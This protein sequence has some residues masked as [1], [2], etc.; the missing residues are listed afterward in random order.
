MLLRAPPSAP[1]LTSLTATGA[2]I[3]SSSCESVTTHT[4]LPRASDC[5]RKVRSSASVLHVRV[6]AAV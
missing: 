5:C 2:S 3:Q 4:L 1:P 6:E